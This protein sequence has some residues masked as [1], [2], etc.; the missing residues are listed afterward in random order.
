MIPFIRTKKQNYRFAIDLAHISIAK[1]GWLGV[2]PTR[3]D[4]RYAHNRR[5]EVPYRRSIRWV[6]PRHPQSEI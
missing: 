4:V 6:Y 2:A 3:N 5:C 1:F